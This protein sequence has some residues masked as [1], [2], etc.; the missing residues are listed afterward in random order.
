M[1]QIFYLNMGL[2]ILLYKLEGEVFHVAGDSFVGPVTTNQSLSVEHGVL[3]VSC[4][5][6]FGS[7]SNQSKIY[8]IIQ[9]KLLYP[10][11]ITYWLNFTIYTLYHNKFLQYYEHHKI[12]KQGMKK[13]NNLE[14]ID[15]ILVF[16]CKM[17][18]KINIILFSLE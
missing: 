1:H 4:Q 14:K 9:Y 3:R 7:I 10:K 15:F 8:F 16:W 6:I 18:A 13:I 17:K 12:Q 5:L 11:N 2:S